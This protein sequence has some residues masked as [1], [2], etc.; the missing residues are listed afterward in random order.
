MTYYNRLS[1]NNGYGNYSPNLVSPDKNVPSTINEP[2]VYRGSES[3]RATVTNNAI[4]KEEKKYNFV[5][6]G[7]N[8]IAVTTTNYYDE[9]SKDN[10]TK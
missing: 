5:H 3:T 1:S 8:R 2:S 7:A 6:T 10:K 4:K 9:L